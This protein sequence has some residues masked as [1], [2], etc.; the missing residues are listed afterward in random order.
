MGIIE[1]HQPLTDA[2]LDR[3]G[4]FLE[5]RERNGAMNIEELDGFFA[6]LIAGPELVPPSQYLPEV[7][8][9][10][11]GE[12]GPFRSLDEANEI[13]GLLLRHWNAIA[14]TLDSGDVHVPIILEDERG[15]LVG[16]DWANG[17]MWGMEFF[18][19]AAGELLDDEQAG[20]CILPMLMLHQEHDEDPEMRPEPISSEKREEIIIAMAAGLSGA[21]EYFRPHRQRLAR[22][23]G[24]TPKKSPKIGRNDA[25]P[26]GSGRKYKRCCGGATIH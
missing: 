12:S 13:L 22:S 26:C 2:E 7:F 6:A 11:L 18:P 15:I 14:G 16:N 4:E 24:E 1:Q 8:G 19:S 5:R 20:G 9:E 23:V 10:D 21:Y 25:C 3:L 17:F